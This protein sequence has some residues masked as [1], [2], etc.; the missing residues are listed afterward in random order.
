MNA[1]PNHRVLLVGSDKN[2]PTL[3]F[4]IERDSKNRIG[5][6]ATTAIQ[7]AL[8]RLSEKGYDAV[9]Y[10]AEREDELAGVIRIRKKNPKL[11]I[12]VITSR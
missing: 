7:D 10:W 9:V 1:A 5:A 3:P 6:E 2:L 12:L 11:P 8:T 4:V